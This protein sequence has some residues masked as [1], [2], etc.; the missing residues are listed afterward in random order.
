MLLTLLNGHWRPA[1]LPDTRPDTRVMSAD[2]LGDKPDAAL[3][4]G[5]KAFIASDDM[6]VSALPARQFRT[7]LTTLSRNSDDDCSWP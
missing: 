5:I 3:M 4:A 6:Q 7:P 1:A 2:A